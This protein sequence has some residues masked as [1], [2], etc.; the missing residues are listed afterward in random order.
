V[1]FAGV[2]LNPALLAGL[3]LNAIAAV[4]PK[5]NG[6]LNEGRKFIA[7]TNTIKSE[8]LS[9]TAIGKKMGISAHFNCELPHTLPEAGRVWASPFNNHRRHNSRLTPYC[10]GLT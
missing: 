7:A 3:K 1:A 6:Y 2:G 9:P 10:F 5:L 8:L 4:H